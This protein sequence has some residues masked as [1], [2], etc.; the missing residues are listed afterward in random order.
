MK[1]M[2]QFFQF[3]ITL[4]SQAD[5]IC[6]GNVNGF[7][8]YK[9][10]LERGSNISGYSISLATCLITK[11]MIKFLLCQCHTIVELMMLESFESIREFGSK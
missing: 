7:A 10:K 8:N 1:L 11:R 2:D 3:D 5:L 9:I 6:D 4:T